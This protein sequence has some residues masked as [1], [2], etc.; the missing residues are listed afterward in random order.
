VSTGEQLLEH[1]LVSPKA[2]SL[3][4]AGRFFFHVVA[5]LAHMER[6]LL[7]LM[8]ERTRAGLAA[9][10]PRGSFGGGSGKCRHGR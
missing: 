10:R 8:V 6:E 4:P 2:A 7:F 5:S 9:A 1:Q 3:K